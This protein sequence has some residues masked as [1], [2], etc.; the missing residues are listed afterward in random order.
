MKKVILIL[1]IVAISEVSFAQSIGVQVG[2]NLA[3]QSAKSD[4]TGDLTFSTKSK[5]GFLFG[6]VGDIPIANSLSF[7]PELNY[8][9]KG[10]KVTIPSIQENSTTLNYLELPLNIIY[11]MEAGQG[12]FFFGA[13]PSIALGL[14]GKSKFKDLE[15]GTPEETTDVKFDGKKQADVTDDKD[16][17]KAIDFGFN[18]LAGYKLSNGLFA[19][20]GYTLGLS[21]IS[22][23]SGQSGKNRGLTLKV[24]YCFMN[25]AKK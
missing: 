22:P 24:G 21:N 16:H 2:G 6:V 14:S 9:Q 4:D 8:I 1:A 7:R 18:L 25:G 12:N 20:I 23:E 19:N 15:E 13:G 10:G 3:S 11:N 5:L 17:L